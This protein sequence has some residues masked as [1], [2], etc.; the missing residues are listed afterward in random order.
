MIKNFLIISKDGVPLFS[1]DPNNCDVESDNTLIG[2]FLSAIQ[3]FAKEVSN[4]GIDSIKMDSFTFFYSAK[5]PIFS[6]VAAEPSDD[7]DNRLY[8]IT[9]DRLSRSFLQ[10]YSK[11]DIDIKKG[12][13]HSFS[14]FE[15]EYKKI[16]QEIESLQKQGNKDFILNYFSKAADDENIRGIIIFDLKEDKIIASDIPPD[17]SEK[18]FESFSSMLFSFIDRMGN[19]LKAGKINEVLMRAEKHW[20]GGFRKGD[21][22]VFTIF[23][24]E[25]FG[26]IIPD[27]ITSRVD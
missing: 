14:D 21:M 24:H 26:N 3:S 7:T 18:S 13:L 10:K 12:E 19:E 27:F 25:F 1:T 20:I 2:C 4:S 16:S 23:T 22:A 17:I 8:K 9:A 15:E 11:N 6:I 5:D